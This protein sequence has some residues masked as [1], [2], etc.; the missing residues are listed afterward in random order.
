[1]EQK[2]RRIFCLLNIQDDSYIYHNRFQ[3]FRPFHQ[4]RFELY[5]RYFYMLYDSLCH[6]LDVF[7]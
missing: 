2:Y 6:Y 4:L 5:V 7:G 1:M 3:C